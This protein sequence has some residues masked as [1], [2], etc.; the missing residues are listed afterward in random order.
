MAFAD[1]WD[2]CDATSFWRILAAYCRALRAAAPGRFAVVQ[3]WQMRLIRVHD[4][5]TTV[6][7]EAPFAWSFERPYAFR[8]EVIGSTIEISVDGVSLSA[9][10]D[11]EHALADGGVALIIAGGAASSDEILVAPPSSAPRDEGEALGG[12]S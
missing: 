5:E 10:D 1:K 7:A 11:G 8:V 3:S 12:E 2:F 4:S 6:L 9:H